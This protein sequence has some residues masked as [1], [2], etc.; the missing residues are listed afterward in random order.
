MWQ[1][2]IHMVFNLSA[3]GIAYVDKLGRDLPPKA[4][5]QH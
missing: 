5:A 1:T 3:V 4:A 2:L